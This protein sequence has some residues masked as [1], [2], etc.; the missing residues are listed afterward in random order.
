MLF[1]GCLGSE[2]LVEQRNGLMVQPGTLHCV[3]Q[4]PA[5]RCPVSDG[6]DW[7]HDIP[8]PEYLTVSS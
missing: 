4:Q 3:D 2:A 6:D 5:N 8:P 7:Q 1:I